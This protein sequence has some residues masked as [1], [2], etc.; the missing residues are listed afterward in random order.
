MI[1]ERIGKPVSRDNQLAGDIWF[2]YA[3]RYGEYLADTRLDAPDDFLLAELEHSPASANAYL[4]LGDFYLEQGN[5]RKAIEQYDYTL[6]LT[7]RA[8]K[9]TTSSRWPTLRIRTE[10][11][12]LRN[13]S[14][15]LRSS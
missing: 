1:G 6:E 14:F 11:K 7:P 12:P 2:Y 8:S 15:S 13:G 4:S 9:S 3:S 5:V 10:R